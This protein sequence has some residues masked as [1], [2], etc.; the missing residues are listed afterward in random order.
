M[1][2]MKFNYTEEGIYPSCCYF[3]FLTFPPHFI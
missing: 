2:F 3:F 1:E